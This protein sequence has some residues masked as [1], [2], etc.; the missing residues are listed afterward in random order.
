ME[1]RAYNPRYA[2]TRYRNY[3]IHWQHWL[4]AGILAILFGFFIIFMVHNMFFAPFGPIE[5]T[6]MFGG[7]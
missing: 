5:A 3:L 6:L 1:A 4:V 2:R 7:R